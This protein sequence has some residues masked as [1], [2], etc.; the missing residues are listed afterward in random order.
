MALADLAFQRTFAK[1]FVYNVLYEDSEQDDRFLGLREDSTVLS[2]SGAGCGIAG[3]V[4][5]H[6]RAIDAIDVNKHHLS[7]TG[8]KVAASQHARNHDELYDLFGRGSIDEP[9]EAV[10]RLSQYLPAWMESYWSK[11][12]KRFRKSFY[13]T[14]MTAQMMTWIRKETEVNIQ[15]LRSLCTI[16]NLEQRA[17]MI[18]DMFMPV[19]NRPVIKW[20]LESPL[21]LLA[22]GVNFQQRDR[23]LDTERLATATDF[24]MMYLKRLAET[25][26][27]TNWFVWLGITGSFNHETEKAVPPYL[28][29]DHH[30]RA[31]ESP[32][33]VRY[34]NTNIF[35]HL[36]DA[37]P[38]TWSHFTLC[39][40]PDWMNESTQK[41]LLNQI[42]RTSRDGAIILTRSVETE[43]FIDRLDGGKN[44]VRMDE[45]SDIATREDRSK[46]YR[47]VD[48]HRVVN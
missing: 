18:E 27:E 9:A 38:Q 21:Q 43:S 23:M 39:D 16:E 12:W 25:D 30:A 37:A 45:A 28:R 41:R 42:R 3:M 7:V 19:F 4:A 1:L 5:H 26:L 48:F 40:A 44:F 31:K 6:P 46:L 15:W 29:R 14:G 35:H 11:K 8:L 34:H 17:A 10:G 13:N 24:F 20:A 33:Q 47:R 36:E 32:T 2:I 22:L